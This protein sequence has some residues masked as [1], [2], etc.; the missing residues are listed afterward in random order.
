VRDVELVV[1]GAG[2]AGVAAARS[3]ARRGI[4]TVL[5]DENPVDPANISRNVPLWYGSR[6]AGRAKA[7]DLF[8]WLGAHPH[9]EQAVDDGVELLPG[10]SVWGL[11]P[12]RSVALFDGTS[13]SLLHAGQVILAT[14]AT[15]L[16]LA[17]P[18]WT[19]GGVLGGRGALHLLETYGYLEARRMLVLGSGNLA[20]EVARR[21]RAH[22]VDIVGIVEIGC[23]VT[24]DPSLAFSLRQSGVPFYYGHTVRAA[25]G[26]ADVEQVLLAK[27]DGDRVR[28]DADTVIEADTLCVAIGCQP[29]IELAYL[30]GCELT[31]DAS[32][33]GYVPRHDQY[34]RTTQD[35]ILVAGDAAGFDD[36]AFLDPSRAQQ[37]G[38]R[39]ALT[40]SRA[41][42]QNQRTTQDGILVAGDAAGF[43]DAAFLDPSR[44]QQSGDRAALTARRAL[45]Q[46]QRSTQDGI[47][48]ADAAGFD[49]AAFL[50]PSRAQQAG[51]RAALTA[52]GAPDQ[53]QRTT[54]DGI[55]V[56]GDA[57][58]FD[59][60]AFL[61]PSRAQQ[62]GDRAAPAA[63][64]ALE[65]PRMHQAPLSAHASAY[66]TRWHQLADL[67]STDDTIVCRC[68]EITRGQV[69]HALDTTGTSD[70]N[71]VKR[72]SRAG[73]GLCQGRGCRPIVAGLL[74]SRTRQALTDVP[75]ASYRPPVRPL[76]LS[77]L[78][79]E[80]P[81][82][83]ALSQPFEA[84][85]A[86]LA[87]AARAGEL[88]PLA[89]A[90]FRRAAEEAAFRAARDGLDPLAV[91]TELEAQTRQSEQR[92]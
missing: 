82:P 17:F 10:H 44:A 14:G 78:A 16:H 88:R 76:P 70:P 92:G 46:N 50:D 84:A 73:M 45:D 34:Q 1:V 67:V 86:R 36:A 33:G 6:A 18:G 64:G 77:A 56:A 63:S 85:E 43:D 66:F 37:S 20:L 19:L 53:N 87:E 69:L 68:E 49:D 74:A 71:E 61:D 90:R 83:P 25:Q 12:D 65:P 26:S 51:N 13:T 58:R 15:D 29:A 24:G 21:A 42:D 79:T 35:G 5:V 60:A 48:V 8:G 3:A 52:T 54:Q 47:L 41:L 57:A 89:L 55:L 80:E 32:R 75:L 38:E 22:G 40:A 11:F 30:A 59:D 7:A 23:G 27:V 62:A 31:F 81:P 2:P 9:L 28:D 91:A 72:V 39:A 4:Q